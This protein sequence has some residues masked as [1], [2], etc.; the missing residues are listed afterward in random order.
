MQR[1][2]YLGAPAA[3]ELNM[4]CRSLVDAFGQHI[5]L[6]GSCIVRRDHR[7]VDVRC[8]LPDEDYAR[9][10]P[11]GG[12]HLDAYWSL[13]VTSISLWLAKR[14]GL[15]IDFQIQQ[16]TRA[17]EQFSRANGHDRQALGLFIADAFNRSPSD[18]ELRKDGVELGPEPQR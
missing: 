3:Y 15:N 16:Q 1:A 2:N 17:N 7:D 12:G 8:I 13:L 10:F 4:A 18:H 9:L 5:Y 14:T 11:G 6:V